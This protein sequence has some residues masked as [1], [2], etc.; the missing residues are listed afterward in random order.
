[1]YPGALHVGPRPTFEGA[2]PS[3]ELHVLDFE[4]D[5]YGSRV[6]VDF[7]AKIREVR[8]FASVGALVDQMHSDVGEARRI[9]AWA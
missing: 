2:N 1:M 5:L 8:S 6:R 7:R 9:L 3:I 4:G